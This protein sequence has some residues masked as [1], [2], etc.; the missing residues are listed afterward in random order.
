MFEL[1][2]FDRRNRHWPFM[3]PFRE[4][5]ELERNFF[6]RDPFGDF[7]TD[8]QD[9]GDAYIL[10][11]ELP[12]FAKEDIK[13]DVDDNYITI[14]AERRC[15]TEEKDRKGNYI[16]SE[17]SYGSVS[18][19]F[20]ISDVKSEQITASYQNGVLKLNMPKKDSS[21]RTSRRIEIQ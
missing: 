9:V 19:S 4:L 11:A 5:E 13:I 10:E 14:S 6:S 20:D 2:P 21:I 8:I 16:R 15:E 7:R 18:R 3:N 12:G 1:T 17:R